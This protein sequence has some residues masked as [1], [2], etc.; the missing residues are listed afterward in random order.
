MSRRLDFLFGVP[1]IKT[2]RPFSPPAPDPRP[3]PRK[4]LL[5]KLAAAG[6]AILMVPAV[7][8]LRRAL[9]EAR[10]DWL[11]SPINA[12]IASTVPYIDRPIVWRNASPVSLPRMASRL[13]QEKYDAIVDLEQWSRGTA[14]LA[15]FSGAPVRVGFATPGQ[16]KH[17]L[18][19][20]AVPKRFDRHEIDE[21]HALLARLAPL[22]VDPALELWETDG[23]KREAQ[24]A[25]RGLKAGKKVLIHPGCGHD[26]RPREWPLESYAVI[27]HWL[28]RHHDARIILSG[29]P[30]EVQKTRG[31]NRL[32][33][34]TAVDLGGKLSWHGLTSV[35]ANADVVLSGNTGV[36]HVAAALKRPQVALHGPTNPALWGPANERAV[37]V[38][39]ACPGCP[40]LR[41]G[42]EYHRKD[43]S[44]M[45]TIETGTVKQ[46]ILSAFDKA[47]KI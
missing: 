36:M 4:I 46:A 45:R 13:R 22:E 39:S 44:C 41:L 38:T 37:V 12:A 5:I 15:F 7:R 30:E 23:G 2:L 20:D 47:G 6:D 1:A 9:P 21:F 25:L 33:R 19:T 29:G 42:F 40:C 3:A 8:A 27:G 31:L 18:F 24:H 11:M 26:G 32:L 34:R 16:H 35:I 14:L 17:G 43:Q 28:Q 10:I